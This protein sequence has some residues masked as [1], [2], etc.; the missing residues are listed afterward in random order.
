MIVHLLQQEGIPPKP[1]STAS[2][3]L[4]CCDPTSLYPF[5]D[6]TPPPLFLCLHSTASTA[7]APLPLHLPGDAAPQ[8]H[9]HDR[10]GKR[11]GRGLGHRM[12]VLQRP[13]CG[14]TV[15]GM[16]LPTAHGMGTR[17]ER[18][19]ELRPWEMGTGLRS[20]LK[21]Q[22][23][24]LAAV[25]QA[26]GTAFRKCWTNAGLRWAGR[27]ALWRCAQ[28]PAA[29][30][31]AQTGM[32]CAFAVKVSCLLSMTTEG[33]GQDNCCSNSK[34]AARLGQ[35]PSGPRRLTLYF[36]TCKPSACFRQISVSIRPGGA[37][38]HTC[39]PRRGIWQGGD[40]QARSRHEEI[41]VGI[42]ITCSCSR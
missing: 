27:A 42:A 2:T 32:D 26:T 35:P 14:R 28:Q 11:V 19:Q 1:R 6:P 5:T 36:S 21:G 33:L 12:H 15:R 3:P 39:M 38:R 22:Y 8:G 7:S 40:R 17:N 29:W 10:L 25:R 30:G 13:P 20:G 4:H 9:A 18:K 16:H 34:S 37:T 31:K 41:A 24:A 23:G